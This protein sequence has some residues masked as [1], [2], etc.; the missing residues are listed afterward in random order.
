LNQ[1]LSIAAIS[2]SG[3]GDIMKRDMTRRRSQVACFVSTRLV[4][5]AIGSAPEGDAVSE[6][7]AGARC[8]NSAW[9]ALAK[10]CGAALW[11]GRRDGGFPTQSY[12]P[13]RDL[14]R[15]KGQ[16]LSE[17]LTSVNL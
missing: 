16:G 8:W 13:V 2:G 5:G 15:Q 7:L 17:H 10:G 1:S 6:A 4:A 3:V 14:V 12:G 11:A 9:P